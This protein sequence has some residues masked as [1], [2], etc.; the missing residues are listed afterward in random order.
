MDEKLRLK[1][2]FFFFQENK[3]KVALLEYL[4]RQHP[5]DTD[6]FS[7]VAHHF[8]MHREIAQT[9]EETALKQLANLGDC[10]P[11]TESVAIHANI[12]TF[13]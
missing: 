13:I 10:F 4:R 7:M 9:L 11:G 6:K 1:S 12:F 8:S 2:L 3:L 5:D